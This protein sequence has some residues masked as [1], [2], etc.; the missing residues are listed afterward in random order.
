MS[1]VWIQRRDTSR[2]ASYHVRYRTGGRGTPIVHA[3]AFRSEKEA[4]ARRNRILLELAAGYD[5]QVSLA[6]PPPPD[7]TTVAEW[8]RRMVDER[9]L[10]VK[11]STVENWE[12]AGRTIAKHLGDV[13]VLELTAD[14]VQQFVA[15]L[16]GLGRRP[17]YVKMLV[18]L[19]ARVLDHAGVEPN[20][21][22]SGK[23]HLPRR[24]QEIPT[25]PSADHVRTM[26]AFLGDRWQLPLTVLEQTGMRV[27]ELASLEWQDVDEQR[28]RFRIRD[29]KTR[30]ARRWVNV[31]DWVVA[32]VSATV[33]PPDRH[34]ERRVFQGFN[35]TGFRSAMRRAC[36]LGGIP[37][38]HPHDLRHRYASIQ[39]RRGVPR[40]DLAAQLGHSRVSMLDVYEHVLLE[41]EADD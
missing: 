7:R 36:E 10:A 16:H 21:A 24:E 1:S 40:T 29:G 33:P 41:E 15:D 35:I 25:V 2:G 19:L 17:G 8:H 6:A 38:Y 13:P 23:V 27:S 30:S 28:S 39:A 4:K 34:P 3:G 22:R 12:N 18:S 32:E 37:H 20:P 31:P 5:P 9:G 26:R 11:P 14:R